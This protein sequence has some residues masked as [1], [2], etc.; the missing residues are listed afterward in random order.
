[1]TLRVKIRI[2]SFLVCLLYTSHSCNFRQIT[3]LMIE[4]TFSSIPDVVRKHPGILRH[5]TFLVTQ[6]WYSANKISRMPTTLPILMLSGMNDEVILP[7]HMWDLW[8]AA[9]NRNF[10]R[11]GWWGP[12]PEYI[13]PKDDVF[14]ELPYGEHS[15]FCLSPSL[16]IYINSLDLRYN[17]RSTWILERGFWISKQDSQELS[18][19]S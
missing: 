17:C 4:N 6:K 1:M 19:S 2:R 9:R 18:A 11:R 3:A 15:E 7:S 16:Y 5:L 13:P 8:D 14:K 10:R 12:M